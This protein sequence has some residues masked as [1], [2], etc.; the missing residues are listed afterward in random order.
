MNIIDKLER[1]M[2]NA[3]WS[4]LL[5][6]SLTNVVFALTEELFPTRQYCSALLRL[7]Y[8]LMLLG[9]PTVM[10]STYYCT[11]NV[12][13]VWSNTILVTDYTSLCVAG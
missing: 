1:G 12:V 4:S 2:T 13:T 7:T 5:M 10:T 11:K 3:S 9:H 6:V 8:A